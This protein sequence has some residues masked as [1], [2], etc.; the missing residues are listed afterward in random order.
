MFLRNPQFEEMVMAINNGPK[1]YIPPSLEKA[2]TIL[3]DECKR[4]IDKDL[5]H[6]KDTCYYHGIS[7]VSDVWSNVRHMPLINILA[8]NSRSAVFMYA[9][10]FSGVEKMRVSIVEFFYQSY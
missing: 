10:D 8:V 6:I 2:R 5:A 1:G 7:F 4:Y 9:D 3:L